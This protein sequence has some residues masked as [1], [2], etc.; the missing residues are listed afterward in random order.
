M[1]GN[2]WQQ[3]IAG[4]PSLG[5]PHPHDV[6]LLV[7]DPADSNWY[8]IDLSVQVPVETTSIFVYGYITGTSSWYLRLS[9]ASGGTVHLEAVCAG[10]TGYYANFSGPC[11]ISSDRKIWWCVQSLNVAALYMWMSEYRI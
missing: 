4:E 7:I 1:S 10:A 2:S 9:D 3:P 8:S 6:Q 11:K 5:T